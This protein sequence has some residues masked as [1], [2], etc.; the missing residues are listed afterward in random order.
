MHLLS[1]TKFNLISLTSVCQ[2]YIQPKMILDVWVLVK[3]L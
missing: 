2:V 3:S 1:D